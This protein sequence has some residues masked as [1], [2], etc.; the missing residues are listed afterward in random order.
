M[1]SS[2][3]P[4]SN[5][6]TDAAAAYGTPSLVVRSDGS[7]I[8]TT[9][10][11]TDGTKLGLVQNIAWSMDINGYAT[12]TV[13]TKATPA[14][15]KVLARDARY[16]VVPALGYHPLCYLWDYYATKAYLWW[17]KIRTKSATPT[18]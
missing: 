12:A 11:L 14:E 15:F 13:V 5:D 18:S 3:V 16:E 10:E 4:L 6:V 9:I 2:D 1:T 17:T 7:P 8:R